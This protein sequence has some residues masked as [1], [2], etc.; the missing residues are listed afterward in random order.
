VTIVDKR[1]KY[2]Q[3]FIVKTYCFSYFHWLLVLVI[4]GFSNSVSAD[5]VDT[6]SGRG[7]RGKIS[8]MNANTVTVTTSGG[9]EES[10]QAFDVKRITFDGEPNGL[11]T[12]RRNVAEGQVNRVE[13]TLDA[14]EPQNLMQKIEKNYLIVMANAQLALRGEG[15]KKIELV[16]K[17]LESFVNDRENTKWYQ[18]F[19][20][21]EKF[22][23]LEVASRNLE[24]ASQQFGMLAKSSSP[25]VILMGQYKSGTVNVLLGDYPAA[26]TQFA[27]VQSSSASDPGSVRMKLLAKVG[28]ARCDAESGEAKSAIT[29]ILNVI[30]NED[31]GDMDLFGRS[32]NALGHCYLKDGQTKAA[33]LAFLH[34]DVLYQRDAEIHAEALFQLTKLWQQDQKPAQSLDAKKLLTTKYRNTFWGGKAQSERL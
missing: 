14:I 11:R 28:A 30:K 34:T 17:E 31:P 8:G 12:A 27:A 20:A 25:E 16:R 4:V 22:G 2:F 13:E 10:I 6:K 32:Y 29:T 26:K 21:I 1:K 33:L 7:Y 18:F 15:G 3:E 5:T 23:D 9:K 24:N 19:Q